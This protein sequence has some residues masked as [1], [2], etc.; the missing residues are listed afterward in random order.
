MNTVCPHCKED[1]KVEMTSQFV[2]RIDPSIINTYTEEIERLKKQAV[3]Q[4]G[5][6]GGVMYLAAERGKKTNEC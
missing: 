2:D 5:L 1:L 4:G 6:E 3:F